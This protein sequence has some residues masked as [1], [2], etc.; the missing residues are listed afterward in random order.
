MAEP[1]RPYIGCT[2]SLISKA[3]IRYTG[4]LASI[5]TANTTLTLHKVQSHGTEDRTPGKFI[6]PQPGTYDMIIFNG[7]DIEDLSVVP[8]EPE[9]IQDP[10]I[11][12]MQKQNSP[13]AP[14]QQKSSNPPGAIGQKVNRSN[15][16]NN[17]A[18][19]RPPQANKIQ[20]NADN[21]AFS[22]PN[23]NEN[24]Q[25]PPESAADALKRNNTKAQN[26]AQ[27]PVKNNQVSA[28]ERKEKIQLKQKEQL[29]KYKEEFDFESCNAKFNKKEL[30]EKLS[31][32][33]SSI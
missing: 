19:Q 10:A 29:E 20:H 32:T 8:K 1:Q 24:S 25:G 18:P 26:S 3:K 6:P 2:L 22:K 17:A 11:L 12:N 27:K 14:A 9:P 4:V 23:K 7:H 5:D 33:D 31:I 28:Q 13:Q 21:S 30:M 16:N 15:N